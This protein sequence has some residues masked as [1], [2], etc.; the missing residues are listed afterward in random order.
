MPPPEHIQTPH[1]IRSAHLP[2]EHQTVQSNLATLRNW[3]E[4]SVATA[5]VMGALLPFAVVWHTTYLT[6][7]AAGLL[8]AA[9]LAAACHIAREH[10]LATLAIVPELT[11]LPEFAAKH[12]RLLSTQNRQA[13][14]AGLRRTADQAQP[15]R[16]FDTCPILT[17]RVA[18]VRSGLL[19]LADSL[20][21]VKDFDVASVALIHEL[22]TNACGPL[23][24]PNVPAEDLHATLTRV[25]AGICLC[26]PNR[27]GTA[28]ADG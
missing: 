26:A 14:A 11:H 3:R 8:G 24:N 17:D 13:L 21:Q 19:Q 16:R 23:Y 18:S 22:L 4:G 10:R 28:G 5:V 15:P 20:E 9:I 6:A 1:E 27:A 25:Q 7:T 2:P 12:K